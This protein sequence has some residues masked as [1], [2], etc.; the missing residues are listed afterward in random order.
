MKTL[1]YLFFNT[2][3]ASEMHFDL[4]SAY[5]FVIKKTS[6]EYV[7]HWNGH[8]DDLVTVAYTNSNGY[9]VASLFIKTVEV[10]VGQPLNP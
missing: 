1:I 7:L 8:S 9:E 6:T 2:P 3:T 4:G 5:S 10:V